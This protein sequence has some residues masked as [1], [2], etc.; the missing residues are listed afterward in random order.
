MRHAL[1]FA[2][3]FTLLTACASKSGA[4]DSALLD[5][6]PAAC[7]PEQ[8][9]GGEVGDLAPEFTLLDQDDAPQALSAACGDVTLLVFG[10][11]WCGKCQAE[12]EELEALYQTHAAAGFSLYAAY[13]ENI[14]GEP[15]TAADLS[16]WADFYG[17]TFPTV[18]DP[19]KVTDRTY[20]PNTETRPTNV[21]LS[22]E[23]RVLSVGGV[24]P[25]EEIG[26]ALGE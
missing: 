22:R 11:F 6:R 21:L 20:D 24:I 16:E 5:A 17:F 2:A 3:S 13:S 1:V 10:T 15:P 12:A 7:D 18:A 14:D 25:E 26:V 9:G 23:G 4:E 19:S 8:L